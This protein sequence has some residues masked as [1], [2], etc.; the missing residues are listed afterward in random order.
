MNTSGRWIKRYTGLL[1]ITA[2]LAACGGG[3]GDSDSDAQPTSDTGQDARVAQMRFVNLVPDAPQIEFF[4]S[5]TS[6]SPFT[7]VLNFG[8]SSARND[9][10]VG[11]FQFNFSYINGQGQRISLFEA[12]DFELTDGDELSFIMVGDLANAE[13]M[14]ID[15]EEFLLGLDDLTAD[16]EPQLQFVHS[17]VGVGAIDFYLTENGADLASA[18]AEAT[19]AFGES[20]NIFDITASTTGQLRAFSAGSTTDLLFDSG[21][22]EFA[23]T[24][25]SM[26]VAA[27]YFGP[28]N[29]TNDNVQLLRYGAIPI[30]LT[31]ADQPS[32]I[33]V[34]NAIADENAV[35]L[36]L[37]ATLG[38]EPLIANVEFTTR[39]PEVVVPAGTNTLL[40]TAA[41]NAANIL[42]SVP[43]A[44]LPSGERR[45]LYVGGE[46]SDPDDGNNINIES[47][48]VTESNRTIAAGAPVRIFNGA[49]QSTSLLV[50]LLR[51]GEAIETSAPNTLPLGG[52]TAVPIVS[53]DFDLV[54]VD[55]TSNATIYGPERLTP[56]QGTT[57][58]I[59]IRDTFGGTIPIVV[60]LVNE[61]T[62]GP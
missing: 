38:A 2:V 53:G 6:S 22:T 18:T 62:I 48:L 55:G 32:S 47:M 35:D 31:N 8:E 51:P 13:L 46:A 20:S 60:D 29:S 41:G 27:N 34:H 28:S 61:P 44:S 56:E 4:H 19:L 49:T 1:A 57:M 43:G 45:T 16:V 23:R 21:S 33:R 25:R 7:N 54:I 15:N 42:L 30:A 24:T 17:A 36:F 10:V 3:G 26:I 14:L 39:S 40:V 12:T 50:F 52:Y 37:D 58:N 11:T 9:F 5:G 59:V